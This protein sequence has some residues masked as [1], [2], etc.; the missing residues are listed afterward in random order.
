MKGHKLRIDLLEWM[1]KQKYPK[2]KVN[3]KKILKKIEKETKINPK[4]MRTRYEK[5]T[6]IRHVFYQ[7]HRHI[8]TSP[9]DFDFNCVC[10]RRN[11]T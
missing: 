7:M 9:G 2:C 8:G 5:T 4:H 6:F 1:L 10:R 3:L 11:R